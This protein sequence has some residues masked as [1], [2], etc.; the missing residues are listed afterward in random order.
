MKHML[1]KLFKLF[2]QDY[3]EREISWHV[4][5]RTDELHDS[6]QYAKRI[7]KLLV[8]RKNTPTG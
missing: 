8:Q 7:D 6:Y 2:F 5:R 4:Q 3:I 1:Y